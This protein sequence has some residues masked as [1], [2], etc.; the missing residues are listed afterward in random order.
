[1]NLCDLGLGSGFLYMKLKAQT[2]T[3][4]KIVI[5]FIKLEN[6]CA[7]ND[8]IKKVKDNPQDERKYLQIIYKRLIFQIYKNYY[9]SIIKGQIT[10]FFKWAKYLNRHLSKTNTIGQ[11][12]HEKMLSVI[13]H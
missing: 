2:T 7:T 5:G 12:V 10:Q 4:T 6:I 1:M 8:A 9:Y 11:K 3:T 13:I